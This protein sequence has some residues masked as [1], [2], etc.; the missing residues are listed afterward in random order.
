MQATLRPPDEEVTNQRTVS[1]HRL[2]ANPSGIRLKVS[3]LKPGAM[4]PAQRG[5]TLFLLRTSEIPDGPYVLSIFQN[6]PNDTIPERSARL[7]SRQR[8]PSR[9]MASTALG[10]TVT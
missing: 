4:L 8:S 10:P 2:S 9:A 1:G 6:P 7:M 5:I 3:Q